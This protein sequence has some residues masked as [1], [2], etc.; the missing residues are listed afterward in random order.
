MAIDVSTIHLSFCDKIA[1]TYIRFRKRIRIA[2]IDSHKHYRN[3]CQKSLIKSIPTE[4]GR[5]RPTGFY[6][7]HEIGMDYI[8]YRAEHRIDKAIMPIVTAVITA[9]L[10]ELLLHGTILSQLLTQW[11]N[12]SNP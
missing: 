2:D 4:E 11:Q 8:N 6:E 1:L 3:L 9:L 5:P 7:L 12:T 10:T